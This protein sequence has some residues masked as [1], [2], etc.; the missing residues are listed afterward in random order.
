MADKILN[1]RIS[2]KYDT[3]ANWEAKNTVLRMGEVGFAAI[4]VNIPPVNKELGGTS[5]NRDGLKGTNPTVLFKIGDGQ[6]PW[7]ELNWT[8][9]L[10]A[11]VYGWAKESSLTINKNGNGN[12]VSGIEWDATANGGKGGIKFTTAAVATAEDLD[13]LQKEVYGETSREDGKS[14][15]DLLEEDIANNRD[16][17]LEKTVD[18]NTTYQFS[19]PT[20]GDDK[21]KLLIESKEIGGTFAKVVALDFVTPDELTAALGNYYTKDELNGKLHTETEIRGYAADEINTLIGGVSDK[22]TIE[23]INSLIT[24]VNENGAEIAQL[25]TD[26]G[27]ANTNASAAVETANGAATTAGQALE[28][29]NEAL[30]GAEGAAASALAAKASEDK[31][32][33]SEN[34]AKASEE[35]AA[36]SAAE[37]LAS[38]GAAAVSASEA[39][40]YATTAGEKAAAANTAK[41]GAEAAQGAAE[42]AKADAESAKVAA[43]TAKQNAV[44]AQV[45]AE[46]AKSAA[47]GS[48]T[49]A[50]GSAEA[51]AQSAADASASASA[52][53]TAQ[54]EAEKAQ[55]AAAQSVIDAAA[56]VTKAQG[57]ASDAD[58]A[59]QAAE[60]AQAAAEASN[61]SATAIANE[62]K[63]T[64]DAAKTASETATSNVNTLT[65]KVN[66]LEAL[67]FIL[68][69][70]TVILDCGGAE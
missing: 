28:K 26:V 68:N 50:A 3:L 42:S 41:E 48:A 39:S 12:V 23:N 30:E 31:A 17:W 52:A 21:G 47:E 46:S 40:G 64:A 38:Q 61:T 18:T 7:K 60:A 5:T 29:A 53:A 65:S 35:A 43:E 57:F 25:T 45:G 10:A 8:N 54:S 70:D 13:T 37:A 51:A 2:L 19:I 11:D 67:D 49:A 14:R 62:A 27:T 6:T 4:D 24:Y 1:T 36:G 59:K 34:A 9:A 44:N 66:A 33:G 15:I 58:T 32:K 69:G 16:A 22:D 55:A 20:E 56:E 63:N